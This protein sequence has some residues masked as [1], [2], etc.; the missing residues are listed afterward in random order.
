MREYCR[1]KRE[2]KIDHRFIHTASSHKLQNHDTVL[3]TLSPVATKPNGQLQKS[4]STHE[5]KIDT[6]QSKQTSSAFELYKYLSDTPITAV[7]TTMQ[8]TQ[9]NNLLLVVSSLRNFWEMYSTVYCRVFLSKNCKMFKS[10]FISDEK[11]HVVTR[12][13]KLNFKQLPKHTKRTNDRSVWGQFCSRN[14]FYKRGT[15][16]TTKFSVSDLASTLH[17]PQLACKS[18][19]KTENQSFVERLQYLKP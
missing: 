8:S 10:T 12:F 9:L 18:Q 13:R 5:S 2:A 3:Q 7:N 4:Q 19:L 14:R 11:H 15:T 17:L 1:L 16:Q 6:V